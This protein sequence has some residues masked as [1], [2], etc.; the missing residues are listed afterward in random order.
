MPCSWKKNT[1]HLRWVR[2][3]GRLSLG[4]CTFFRPL[5]TAMFDLKTERRGHQDSVDHRARAIGSG[6]CQASA[7][8]PHRQRRC[9][10]RTPLEP[11]GVSG[12]RGSMAQTLLRD[13]YRVMPY[14][15]STCLGNSPPSLDLQGVFLVFWF[16]P[17]GNVGSVSSPG[18]F[19]WSVVKFS[20]R[21]TVARPSQ[22]Y[23]NQKKYKKSN[24]ESKNWQRSIS[25]AK[26]WTSCSPRGGWSQV[27]TPPP[28]RLL[29]IEKTTSSQRCHPQTASRRR[30]RGG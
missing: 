11:L 18:R 19:C 23:A 13:M 22:R 14:R 28:G 6:L 4:Q 25:R 7:V 20:N 21:P 24:K 30:C 10:K 17:L 26:G 5:D 29:T 8:G 2:R 15:R 12:F 9:A 3:E 1:V 16:A 27:S